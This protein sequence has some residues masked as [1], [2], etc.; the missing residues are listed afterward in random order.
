MGSKPVW[1]ERQCAII[2][3]YNGQGI[4]TDMQ[5]VIFTNKGAD[6]TL[7]WVTNATASPEQVPYAQGA[8]PSSCLGLVTL[9]PPSPPPPSP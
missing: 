6:V 8:T 7:L 4:V 3:R 2:P 5:L 9:N 1:K